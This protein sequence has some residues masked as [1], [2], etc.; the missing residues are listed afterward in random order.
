MANGSFSAGRQLEP[1]V[2]DDH[3]RLRQIERGEGRIDRQRQDA[4]GERDLVVLKPV[5]LAAED[6]GDRSRRRR[7]AARSARRLP[8]RRPRAWPGRGRAR[9][10]QRRTCSRRS[11]LRA[12]SKSSAPSR[13]RSAPAAIIRA[14]SLGQACRGATSRSRDRPKFAMARAA[15]PIFSP[16]CGSTRMTIGPAVAAQSFVLS[17]PAPGIAPPPA[18]IAKGGQKGSGY[19]RFA[20]F[21]AAARML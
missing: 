15:A 9:S 19:L 17:V 13:M 18:G 3:H 7:Y 12:S 4:I 11:P 8:P 2:G 16:S 1:F 20:P 6:D 14:L 21:S 5:A 10:R